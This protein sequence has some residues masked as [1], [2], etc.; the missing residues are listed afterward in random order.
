MVMTHVVYLLRLNVIKPGPG[1]KFTSN[2]HIYAHIRVAEV[3][4]IN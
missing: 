2:A 4:A 3:A 1:Y